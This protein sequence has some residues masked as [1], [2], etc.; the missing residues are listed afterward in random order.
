MRP[1]QAAL[2]AVVSALA[3]SAGV[4]VLTWIPPEQPVSSFAEPAVAPGED[5]APLALPADKIGRAHV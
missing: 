1:W 5:G 4:I 2:S 3:I